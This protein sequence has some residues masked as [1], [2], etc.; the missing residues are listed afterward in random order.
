MSRTSIPRAG[1]AM[2]DVGIPTSTAT[3]L[4]SLFRDPFLRD[5]FRRAQRRGGL[6]VPV[7][8]DKPKPK[9]ADGAAALPEPAKEAAHG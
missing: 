5:A 2:P 8:A 7:L 6:S 9:L 3:P 4:W 1:E